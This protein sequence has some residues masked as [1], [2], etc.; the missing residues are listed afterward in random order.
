MVKFS[1]L[2]FVCFPVPACFLAFRGAINLWIFGFFN[3]L[4]IIYIY[5]IN[6]PLSYKLKICSAHFLEPVPQSTLINYS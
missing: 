6:S 3:N 4:I 2:S 1:I 5:D